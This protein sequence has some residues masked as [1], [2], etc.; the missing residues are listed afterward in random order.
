MHNPL[1]KFFRRVPLKTIRAVLEEVDP[2]RTYMVIEER[3]SK[4]SGVQHA[5]L[6]NPTRIVTIDYDPEQ[7]APETIMD[8][9]DDLGIPYHFTDDT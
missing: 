9:L 3:F 8:A 7:V 6:D 5:G 1:K 4:I 2:T